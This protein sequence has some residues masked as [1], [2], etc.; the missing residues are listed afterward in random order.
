[1]GA[2][3]NVITAIIAFIL[4]ISLIPV[5]FNLNSCGFIFTEII[6]FII[7]LIIGTVA[8]MRLVSGKHAWGGMF[9]FFF[10]NAI[11]LFIL[12]SRTLYLKELI[13]P[14]IAVIIGLYTAALN[15]KKPEYDEDD[16]EIEPYYEAEHEAEVEEEKPKKKAAKRKAKKK[17]KK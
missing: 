17:S 12:Y 11:N 3:L 5:I 10:L 6:V 13:I 8:S 9:A 1:M 15:I 14:F 16:A 7:L 4:L 2:K